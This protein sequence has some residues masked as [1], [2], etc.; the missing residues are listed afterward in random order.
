MKSYKTLSGAIVLVALA[1][2]CI[3]A[4]SASATTL[5]ETG[6]SPEGPC[7]TGKGESASEIVAKAASVVITNSWSDITCSGSEMKIVP[8]SST[9]API[10]G[11]IGSF[12]LGLP[13]KTAGGQ[14]CT[15]TV[16]NLP[17]EVEIEGTNLA[18]K[19]A[20]GVGATL[21]CGFLIRC[22]FHTKNAAYTIANGS[23]T[24]LS[25]S[26]EPTRTGVLCPP[27]A[28]WHATYSVTSPTGFT[29]K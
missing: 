5:C 23:P 14:A 9:G 27:E 20:V 7:G 6:G 22:G 13:C 26:Y 10:T 4:A 16:D 3:G 11:S 12:I 29:V 1:V 24:T 17:W 25:T 15:I 2:A 21:N 19:D 28:E 8:N 18:I